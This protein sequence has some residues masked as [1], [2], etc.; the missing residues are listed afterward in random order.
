MDFMTPHANRTGEIIDLFIST[1]TNSEGAAE[2]ELIGK[3]VADMFATVD[4]AD[5]FVYSAL[6]GG[7]TA[8]T[9]VFTRLEYPEDERTVFI[10]GPVAVATGRQ[11]KGVGRTLLNHGLTNLTENGVDVALT[12][13]DVDFYAKVGF[14]RITGGVASPPLPLKYP[15]AWL[16]QSLNDRP[17]D[18]LK[19][20]SSCVAAL[21]DPAY[22]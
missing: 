13:G 17:L 5:L 1:F 11:G 18:P 21:N 2:G 19:G 14:A 4:A 7:R 8:G 12:Y 16:G 10:L 22:W 15:E 9:I 3:L 6:E 20:P